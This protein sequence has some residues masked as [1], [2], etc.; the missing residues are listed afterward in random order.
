MLTETFVD[1][2]V[3]SGTQMD[4]IDEYHLE[5]MRQMTDRSCAK[6]N[7]EA[8]EKFMPAPEDA[9]VPKP[10]PYFHS[11]ILKSVGQELILIAAKEMAQEE[12]ASHPVLGMERAS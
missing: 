5:V 1:F 8:P 3:A 10:K 6:A 2:L 4:E 9:P 7:G 12:E 11:E